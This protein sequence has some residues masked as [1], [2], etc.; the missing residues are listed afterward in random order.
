VVTVSIGV[1]SLPDHARTVDG[2]V[3][4]ADH[5][6]YRAKELGKNRVEV[7]RAQAEMAP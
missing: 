5:A 6:L 3:E 4:E 1:A 7:A 2:L